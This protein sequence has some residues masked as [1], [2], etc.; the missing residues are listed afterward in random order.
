[1]GLNSKRQAFARAAFNGRALGGDV[2]DV[3]LTLASS[4]AVRDGVDPDKRLIGPDFPY[5]GEPHALA[6]NAA[7]Q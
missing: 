7:K 5:F 6:A 1:L 4:T 3:I 2:M